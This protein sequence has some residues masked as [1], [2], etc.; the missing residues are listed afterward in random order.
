MNKKLKKLIEYLSETIEY[1]LQK[2]QNVD[3]DLYFAN[4][5]V[6]YILD[7]SIN[8]IIL[9]IVDIC[10]EILKINKRSIPDTYKDTILACYEF[11]GDL[12]LKLAPLA[13]CR[14]EIVH[15]YLKVNWQNIQIVYNKIT[16]IQ[17]FIKR[18]K[19]N[20]LN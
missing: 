5:D 18:I 19:D 14:N 20:F 9:C 15:Q 11:I 4:R 6:R 12:A 16:E 10:E 7:K 13:K 8:D 17:E 2:I 1:F 3:K